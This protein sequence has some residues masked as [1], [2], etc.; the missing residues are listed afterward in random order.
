MTGHD[1]FTDEHWSFDDGPPTFEDEHWSRCEV[2]G[3]EATFA[4]S[5][6]ATAWSKLHELAFPGHDAFDRGGVSFGMP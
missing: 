1:E 4:T 5:P 2:C 3:Q 6:A